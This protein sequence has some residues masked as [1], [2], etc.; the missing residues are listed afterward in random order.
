MGCFIYAIFGSCRDITIGPT[1]LMA[2]MTYQQVI[3]RNPDFAV[4]LC[5]LSGVVQIIMCLCRLGMP[6]Q[7]ILEVIVYINC[8]LIIGVLVDF[9]SIPVTVGFTSATSVIIATSQLKGL[10][11][12]RFKSSGFLDTV[13]KVPRHIHETR[14]WDCLLGFSC[15][16]IL[17]FL[18]VSA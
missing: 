10:L 17:L 7:K 9:I 5:F 8:V 15:I 6:Y 12:L 4:L 14:F 11:G 3:N 2:L 16:A 13:A 1:A 18:R